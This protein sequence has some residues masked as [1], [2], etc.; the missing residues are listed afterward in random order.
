MINFSFLNFGY[1]SKVKSC[2]LVNDFEAHLIRSITCK[3]IV[4]FA[5][6]C[7]WTLS[8][9]SLSLNVLF[10]VVIIVVVVQIVF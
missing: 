4:F 8:Y 5:N 1:L 6:N 7:W 10:V 3:A 2:N 9:Y